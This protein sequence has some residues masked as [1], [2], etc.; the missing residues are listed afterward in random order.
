[1]R[2]QNGEAVLAI[3]DNGVGLEPDQLQTVFDLF[4]QG[5][6][7]LARSQGGLGVGLTLA[8]RLIELHGGRIEAQSPGLG[9]GSTFIVCLPLLEAVEGITTALTS[10]DTPTQVHR[11]LVIDDNADAA[12]T[13]SMLLTLKGYEVH[14]RPS[15]Q[16]GIQAAAV[17]EPTVI[18]CDIGM[19]ELDGYQTARLI[20]QQTWGQTLVFVA[21]TG[22]GQV[23][24]KQRAQEAGFDAHLVKPIDLD[25]LVRLLTRYRATSKET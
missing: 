6:N 11:F 21:I 1:M 20:R 16:E 19:P 18:L 15:G 13:L 4:V 2:A 12:L 22:Y 25:E 17:L 10:P 9:K 3:A 5:D 8:K 7:S 14:S 24:D 23:D